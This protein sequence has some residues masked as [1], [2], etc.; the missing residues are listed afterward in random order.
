MKFKIFVV[1]ILF[2]N[3]II[4]AQKPIKIKNPSFEDTPKIA[5]TPTDWM[6]CGPENQTPPDIQ[7]TMDFGP[8]PFA[9]FGNTYLAMVVRDVNIVESI[10][11]KLT[12]KLKTDSCY[13]FSIYLSRSKNYASVSQ[14]TEEEADYLE[15]VILQIW[16]SNGNCTSKELLAVSPAVQNY[17]WV[18]Y[19]FKIKPQKQVKYLQL[20]AFYS[21]DKPY[22]GNIL[23]DNISDIVPCNCKE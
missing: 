18:P 20:T 10:Q 15:P 21:G 4:F 8:Q 12:S 3:T 17:N 13:K 14:K 9:K 5:T 11:Q 16:S 19:I 7:P 22:N 6:D 2:L 1:S 23:L